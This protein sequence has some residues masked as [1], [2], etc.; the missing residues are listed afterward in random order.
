MTYYFY[1]GSYTNFDILAHLPDNKNTGEGIYYFKFVNGEIYPIDVIK[2]ENPAVLSFNPKDHNII[3]VLQEGIV[4]N[5]LITMYNKLKKYD[6]WYSRGRSTCYFKIDP[7]Y[8]FGI[9]INYWEGTLDVFKMNKKG[10]I[11]RHVQHINH[12]D[13]TLYDK[14]IRRQVVDRKD[15]WEN[16][17]VGAH[18]H[19]I[20][21]VHNNV[22][23]P[24]LGENSIFQYKWEPYEQYPLQYKSQIKLK[25]GCGP[26]HMVFS[27]QHRCAYVS[28]ELN[29]TVCVLKMKDDTLIPIQYIKTHNKKEK[30]YVAEIAISN[31]K[32]FIYVSNR[33]ADVISIFTILPSGQLEY[34]SEISTYGKTPRHFIIT[35]DDKYLISA[36][37]DSNNLI[38]FKRNK[39][40]GLLTFYKKYDNK[41]F[42]KFKFNAPNYIL[43]N[44]IIS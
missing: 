38:V 23:I 9:S 18:A 7:T 29:S 5:G 44:P 24:D 16:R 35:P 15:H 13:L 6:E 31:D 2:T 40:A 12:N 21:Y 33:G 43:F 39:L 34:L 30:N 41:S 17:Q 37:Q 42:F 22:Y 20:H 3:Y 36:N 14:S 26:R 25:E 1:V 10:T 19:S 32:N 4:N 27:F 8:R 28:N 11:E